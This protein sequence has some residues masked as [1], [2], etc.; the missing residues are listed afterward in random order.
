MFARLDKT[1]DSSKW[2]DSCYGKGTAS[3]IITV[4][5]FRSREVCLINHYLRLTKWDE[6]YRKLYNVIGDTNLVFVDD[7]LVISEKGMF[8]EG[9]KITYKADEGYLSYM[10]QP[11]LNKHM[12]GYVKYGE[13]LY[14]RP[15]L[16]T[17][18]KIRT[19]S[20]ILD[21]V[22]FQLLS[23]DNEHHNGLEPVMVRGV[24]YAKK[25]S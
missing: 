8:D 23:R 21:V 7:H 5:P 18:E 25:A 4:T 15:I 22:G 24:K 12:F 11:E 10:L 3:K 9:H 17:K 6:G 20:D 19:A 14:L 16:V 2:E 1:M 13:G